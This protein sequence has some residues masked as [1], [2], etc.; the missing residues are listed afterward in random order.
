[1]SDCFMIKHKNGEGYSV[2]VDEGGIKD[3]VLP[4]SSHREALQ[5]VWELETLGYKDK[6]CIHEVD[7]E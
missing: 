5:K 3:R 7:N 4:T 6:G 2:W 1:M